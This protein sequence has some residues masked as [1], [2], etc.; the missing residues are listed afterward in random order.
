MAKSLS[1][2][3]RSNETFELEITPRSC[4]S[5]SFRPYNKSFS[6]EETWRQHKRTHACIHTCIHAYIQRH[7]KSWLN[8]FTFNQ[9]DLQEKTNRSEWRTIAPLLAAEEMREK[10]GGRGE[11]KGIEGGE[12]DEHEGRS[13]QWRAGKDSF[14]RRQLVLFFLF[15]WLA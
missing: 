11:W 10:E 2:S 1:G 3:L 13:G 5:V 12:D 6:L 8:D 14:W 9:C 15:F 4:K 7:I